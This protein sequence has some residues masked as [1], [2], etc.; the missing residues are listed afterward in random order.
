MSTIVPVY[1]R[2][3][4]SAVRLMGLTATIL[5]DAKECIVPEDVFQLT[6]IS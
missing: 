2:A 6:L 3:F 5:A 4:F 1:R